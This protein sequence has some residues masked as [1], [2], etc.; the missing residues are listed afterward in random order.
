MA[1]K[2]KPK[3]AKEQKS[4]VEQRQGLV[5]RVK[6]K[7]YYFLL[8]VVLAFLSYGIYGFFH[9]EIETQHFFSISVGQTGETSLETNAY[10]LGQC[11]TKG[12]GFFVGKE[13]EITTML[14]LKDK[15]EYENIKNFVESA[16]FIF[17]ENSE[18]PQDA[19]KDVSKAIMEG[20]VNKAF[21]NPGTI[22]MVDHFD[23]NNT[24]IFRGD[25]IFTK[26]G[27]ITFVGEPLRTVMESHHLS[28][29]GMTIE[30]YSTKYQIDI[31]RIV[32]LL[33]FVTISVA[34]LSLFFALYVARLSQ[35]KDSRISLN[36]QGSPFVEG[37]SR[38]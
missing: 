11:K 27:N 38:K 22:R 20:N 7:W 25:V 14:Y 1:K 30:P 35:E 32:L 26:A 12:G 19:K 18:D 5:Q 29:E 21:I 34:F 2:Q 10:I 8:I 3:T 31:N 33:T 13:I 24:M 37:V 16:N 4:K 15:Q 17:I 9:Q 23:G 28:V 36:R 6:A